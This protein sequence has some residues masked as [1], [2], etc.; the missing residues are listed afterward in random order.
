MV[1]VRD[2]MELSD[3]Q[4]VE[5]DEQGVARLLQEQVPGVIPAQLIKLDSAATML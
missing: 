5:L 4:R 2:R 3:V 1:A